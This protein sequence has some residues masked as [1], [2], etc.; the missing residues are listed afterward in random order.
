MV[1]EDSSGIGTTTTNRDI[2]H[3]VFV[4]VILLLLSVYLPGIQRST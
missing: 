1:A 2:S 3:M 4:D